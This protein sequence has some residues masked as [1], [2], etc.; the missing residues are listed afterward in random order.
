[1][2][3]R[4]IDPRGFL[5]LKQQQSTLSYIWTFF[6]KV[7]EQPTVDTRMKTRLLLFFLNKGNNV[8]WLN[9][10]QADNAALQTV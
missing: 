9:Y 1:M 8:Y 5:K 3:F 4:K 2:E 7:A 6:T 10:V